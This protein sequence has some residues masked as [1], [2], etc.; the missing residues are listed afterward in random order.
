MYPAVEKALLN[1]PRH[2]QAAVRPAWGVLHDAETVM[3]QSRGKTAT[4]FVTL[5]KKKQLR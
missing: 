2:N 5:L 4:Q 1:E 3:K